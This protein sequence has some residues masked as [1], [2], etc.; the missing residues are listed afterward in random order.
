MRGKKI[1]LN[2]L[3]EARDDGILPGRLLAQLIGLHL[4]LDDPLVPRS[5]R[6]LHLLQLNED[7]GVE[8]IMPIAGETDNRFTSDI[9]LSRLYSRA[10]SSLLKVVVRS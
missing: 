6:A 5:R 7:R 8:L 10:A 9:S 4:Q 2:A 1:N 3:L